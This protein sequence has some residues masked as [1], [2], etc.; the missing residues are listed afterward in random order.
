MI[1][2]NC[3]LGEDQPSIAFRS[4]ARVLDGQHRIAGLRGYSQNASFQL[5]VT[6][7]TGADLADQAHIFATV[8]LEQ[9]K[10]NKSL[11]YDLYELSKA[12]SPQKTCHNVVVALDQDRKSPLYQRVKRLGLAT[13]GRLFQPVTQATLVEGMLQ[14]ITSDPRADRDIL[15][16][17]RRLPM[18][19]PSERHR[20]PLRGLFVEGR[21][22]DIAEIFYNYFS[23]VK[24]KWPK[25]WE[26]AGRGGVLNRTN[27]IRALLRY[28]GDAYIKCNGSDY[29]IKEEQFFSY[30]FRSIDLADEQITVEE[31]PAGSS[32]EARLLN[33]FRGRESMRR[34]L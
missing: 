2:S 13:S 8:N 21:D 33:V 10:V 30:A 34:L 23:A 5:S 19:D 29:V 17:G 22:L 28:F 16:R 15:L 24:R 4:I 3:R 31:F 18:P 32:G 27:G 26:F 14:Y 25:A 1:V 9:T 11:V 7:F 20:R 12:R 6:I